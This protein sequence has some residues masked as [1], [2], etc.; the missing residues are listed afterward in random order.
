LQPVL[1]TVAGLKKK[2]KQTLNL[3]KLLLLINDDTALSLA[4][5]VLLLSIVSSP[6]F[7]PNDVENIQYLWDIW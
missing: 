2:T 4:R 1:Q 5:N 3:N 6:E 7:D